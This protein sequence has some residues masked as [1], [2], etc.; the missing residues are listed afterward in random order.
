MEL[1]VECL[2][3][4]ISESLFDS[5]TMAESDSSFEL[6][7]ERVRSEKAKPY[8]MV[9]ED[10]F[11]RFKFKS[12]AGKTYN[13]FKYVLQKGEILPYCAELKGKE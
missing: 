8:D 4:Y 13:Y 2:V 9:P 11:F 6:E 3:S 1:I 12:N 10:K 7:I 5:D